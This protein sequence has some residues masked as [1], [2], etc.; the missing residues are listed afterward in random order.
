MLPVG[1]AQAISRFLTYYGTQGANVVLAGLCDAG[2]ERQLRRALERAGFGRDLGRTEME[3]LG[4]YVCER[5][6]ED[7]LTAAWAPRSWKRSSPRTGS[8]DRFAPTRNSRLIERGRPR[9]SSRPLR[10]TGRS[11]S[12]RRSSRRSISAACL[13]HSTASSGTSEA[14]RVTRSTRLFGGRVAP[15]RPENVSG[16]GGRIGLRSSSTRPTDSFRAQCSG[17]TG[18]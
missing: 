12:R 15:R 11:C 17:P 1:G 6:L 3:R 2:E 4:F 9:S 18:C 14:S 5:D 13:A 7:E 10:P 16:G 8:S